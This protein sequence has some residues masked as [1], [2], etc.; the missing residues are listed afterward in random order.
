MTPVDQDARD[1]IT[2][3]TSSTLFVNAGAGSGKT[4]ALVNRITTLVLTD[5]IRLANVAAVTF[6]EKAGAEL[7]DRLR[8]RFEEVWRG[9][10]EAQRQRAAEALEDLDRAAVG[11]LHAFA[12]RILTEHAIS[13]GL[14]PLLEVLDDVGSSVAFEERWAGLQTALLDDNEMERALLLG[15]AA[16]LKLDHVRSLARA[17]GADWDLIGDQVLTTP[18]PAVGVPDVTTLLGRATEV[19]DLAQHCSD[20]EDRL[21]SKF[22]PLRQAVAVLSAASDDGARIGGLQDLKA[23]KF[24]QGRAANWTCP[25]ADVREAGTA[26]AQEADRILAAVLDACLRSV[27][28]WTARHVLEAAQDRQCSGRLE[29]HDLLVLARDLLRRDPEV[30]EALSN[31]YQRLLL[32][33][34][35]DTDPIQ[36]EFAVRI[37]GGAAAEQDRWQD[38]KVPDGRL[39]F[40]GDAKQSIYKFRRASIATYLQAQEHLGEQVHL[41]T[42]FRT[43]EPVLHW[44]NQVFG[45]IIAATPAAQPAYEPLDPHRSDTGHGPAVTILGAEAHTG[46]PR[47]AAD[48][49]RQREAGDV[50]AVI[51]RM[52]T[53]QWQVFDR[54]SETWRA[55]RHDDIAVLVPAR[56]SLPHLEDALDTAG[57]Q[58]RAEASSLVYE[59]AEVRDLLACAR[60]IADPTDE[61]SLLTALRSPLF[62]CGDDDLWNW[63]RGG[64]GFNL[65]APN[66]AADASGVGPGVVGTAIAAIR[67]LAR[68]TRWA[69]PSELLSAIIDDRRM[70]EVA[71]HSP[72]R[73]DAW[74]RLRFVV[75]QARAWSETSHGGLRAYLAWATHQGQ[76]GSRVAESVLPETDADAVRITTIHAAKGLEYPVVIMS[77]M[78]AQPRR[79]NGLRLL[80]PTSGGYEVKVGAGIQTDDFDT[81]APVDEQMDDLERLRLLYVAATRARDHLVVSLHRSA[82]SSVN[83]AAQVLAGAGAV[84]DTVFAFSVGELTSELTPPAETAVA[85][86]DHEDWAAQVSSA[87]VRTQLDGAIVASGLEGTEPEVVLLGEPQD[88]GIHKGPRDLALPPWS[89]GRY[90]SAVGRAVHAVLQSVDLATGRG[91]AEAV[92]AQALAEGVT[93]H[94]DLIRQLVQAALDS[95]LV[96]RAAKR[97]HWRETYVGTAR[98]DGTILEGYVDLIYREDDGTLVIV[99]YKTDAVPAE[100]LASRVTYYKPQITA[101]VECLRAATGQDPRAVLLF[102]HPQGSAEVAVPVQGFAATLPEVGPVP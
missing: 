67:T 90:G 87:R 42:N 46:L 24:T 13:A 14:P 48:I 78:T 44:V 36:I 88:D 23:L 91:L 53:E 16:G 41:T 25:I 82:A 95:N 28:C 31:T 61:L 94:E 47:A 100:G 11:T 39:F 99:D 18:A 5:Q 80:W 10:D 85:V 66:V 93:E 97:E 19:L 101:Y 60:A 83:T 77:G 26:L 92:Q 98:A 72:R 17:L 2:T 68:R 32:D 56:T 59:A 30:R 51:H 7:R 54:Q 70:L 86:P 6:T 74:R 3:D 76:E 102:L 15:M 29:F 33:E 27:T 89:K 37:A 40:V 96:Q 49:L 69:A 12:Q 35:Q 38:I 9:D 52:L 62:G 81:T 84:T 71:A 58:Y 4:S 21:L 75:D 8:A 22:D 1:R 55:V 20:P 65:W 50:A 64:G 57:I 73:R 63:K 45:R 34:F 43:V 79:P